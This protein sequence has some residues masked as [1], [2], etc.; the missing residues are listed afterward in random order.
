MSALLAAMLE[1]M[2]DLELFDR[3]DGFDP[4]LLLAGQGSRFE[5]PFVEY[6][7]GERK[8]TVM[9]RVPYGMSPWKVE[10]ITQQNGKYKDKSK[11]AQEKLLTVKTKQGMKFDIGKPDTMWIVRYA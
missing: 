5:L 2:D 10:D 4:C 3:S 8:R 11:D 6:I 9:I 1:A 7:N